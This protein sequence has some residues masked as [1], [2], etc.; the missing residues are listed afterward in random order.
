[1]LQ[2]IVSHHNRTIN[3]SNMNVVIQAA[4]YMFGPILYNMELFIFTR[5]PDFT[6]RLIFKK[7]KKKTKLNPCPSAC[8]KVGMRLLSCVRQKQLLSKTRTFTVRLSTVG[9]KF[10][11]PNISFVEYDK[12]DITG[13][14]SSPNLDIQRS[15][16]NFTGR[17][18]LEYIKK[19]H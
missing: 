18:F 3:S 1:M 6:S 9:S 13:K 17:Q 8:K 16:L 5:Y 11:T 4:H 7:K 19:S 15:K 14:H 10:G 2:N 12:M